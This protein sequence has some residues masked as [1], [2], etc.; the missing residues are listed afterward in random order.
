LVQKCP[1]R[2]IFLRAARRFDWRLGRND[3]TNFPCL[4]LFVADAPGA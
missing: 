4:V 1:T 2:D 3:N